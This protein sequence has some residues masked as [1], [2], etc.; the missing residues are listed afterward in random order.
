MD[1]RKVRVLVSEKDA[2]EM[3]EKLNRQLSVAKMWKDCAD[4]YNS[5]EFT[6]DEK[7]NKA[8]LSAAGRLENAIEIF[9]YLE[10]CDVAKGKNIG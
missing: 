4:C 9:E 7:A 8:Y 2:M 1:E 6:S 5:A 3:M 10:T